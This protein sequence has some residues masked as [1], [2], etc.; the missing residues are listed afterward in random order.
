M[1]SDTLDLAAGAI[2]R[3]ERAARAGFLGNLK[4]GTKIYLISTFLLLCMAAVGGI[5]VFKMN[6]IGDEIVG[7][8]ERDIPATNNVTNITIHQLEQAIIFERALRFGET[9]GANVLNKEMFAKNVQSFGTIADKVGAEFKSI[10]ALLKKFEKEATQE[11]SKK[12]FRHTLGEIE[13]ADA[14]HQDY[15]RQAKQV[16]STLAAGEARKAHEQA[17]RA[18]KIERE[19][20]RTLIA[21]LDRLKKFTAEAAMT[22]EHD[23]KTALMQILAVSGGAIVLGLL[24]AWLISRA[25][26][27]PLRKVMNTVEALTKGDTSVDLD[28]KSNDEVGTLA[29]GVEIWR[30]AEIERKRLEAEA[31]EREKRAEA[32]K[33]K[34]MNDLADSFQQRVGSTIGTV[35]SAATELQN[36]A[37]AMTSTA[38]NTSSQSTTVAAAAEQATNNV[39]TV[40]SAAEELSA[41]IQEISS[42]VS[43]SAEIAAAAVEEAKLTN[44]K[45]NSLASAA[46]KIGEVVS[47]ITD[48]AEQTNLLALNATIEAA[49]AGDAG[50]GFAVVASEVKNLA[51]QTAK[52]TE[53]IS[54][55]IGSIQG[56]TKDAVTAIQGISKTIN[57]VNEIASAISA[58]VEEQ[59]A[60]TNEIA[61]NVEQAAQGTQDVTTNITKVTEGAGETGQAAGQVLE[62]AGEL[63]KQAEFLRGEVDNFLN[64]VRA[65]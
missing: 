2:D 31:S 36:T 6:M 51:N 58:A 15:G 52:A 1:T 35:A 7:I 47:L 40:S 43:R 3:K 21:T 49:R 11:K 32:E 13:K 38:D 4:I 39:Q 59:G 10:E 25:I 18:E 9:M 22:A 37:Q 20:D 57:E 27:G 46:D 16:F 24:I 23:E 17:E 41:S 50:K 63:S 29:K 34:A 62:A 54:E 30:S 19:L 12:E 44:E 48:I 45:I 26:V 33:R 55:Q 42:Q 8:A 14:L 60:A 53:E 61:R 65:A 64:E 56:A 5:G 28:V